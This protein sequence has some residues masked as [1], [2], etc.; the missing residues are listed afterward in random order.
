MAYLFTI[1]DGSSNDILAYHVLDSITL[2]IVT[3]TIDKLIS[4]HKDSLYQDAFIHSDQSV[5]YTSPKFQ[6]LLKQNNL[7]QSMPRRGNYWDNLPQ[8]SFFGHMK[9]EVDF[10]CYQTLEEVINAIDDYIEYYNNYRY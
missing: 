1:K 4:Q 9:D 10:K 7:G 2:D 5:H 8:E 3:T 6:K